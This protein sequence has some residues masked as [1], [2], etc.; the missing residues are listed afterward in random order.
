MARRPEIVRAR[1]SPAVADPDPRADR[2]SRLRRRCPSRR[3]CRNRTAPRPRA[4]SPEGPLHAADGSDV[5]EESVSE[6]AVECSVLEVHNQQVDVAVAIDIAD[7]T[8]H[9]TGGLSLVVRRD[10]RAHA[11]FLERPVTLVVEQEVQLMVVPLEQIQATVVI[12]VE[13]GQPHALRVGE[14]HLHLLGNVDELAVR[15]CSY[16][17]DA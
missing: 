6:V 13:D 1:R 12:I 10:S 11:H 3:R 17:S 8:M 9:R 2:P 14:V 4:F 16:N 15:P 7:R 5:F